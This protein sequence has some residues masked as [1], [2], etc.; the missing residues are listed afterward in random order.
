MLTLSLIAWTQTQ[1]DPCLS[2]LTKYDDNKRLNVYVFAQ[3]TFRITCILYLHYNAMKWK[4]FPRCWPFVRGIHLSPMNSLHKGQWRGALVITMICAWINVWVN[5][6]EAGD[7]RRHRAHYDIT[8]MFLLDKHMQ[9]LSA[10]AGNKMWMTNI[11]RMQNRGAKPSFINTW[12]P[13]QYKD[14][15]IYV[16]RFP[17]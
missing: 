10:L 15:L 8:V 4:H 13:S 6:C 14:R 3:C 1:N 11:T 2:V 7:L 5:N 12:T 9:Y 17:C 16:W